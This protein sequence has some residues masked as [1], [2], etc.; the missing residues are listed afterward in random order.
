MKNLGVK[1]EALVWGGAFRVGPDHGI[2]GEEVVGGVVIVVEDVF[3]IVKVIGLVVK[4]Y[5][6]NEL[7]ME[8]RV[9]EGALN[10]QLGVYLFQLFECGA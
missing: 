10:N 7:A 9:V 4:G 2:E 1:M 5:G 6:G 3:G 8:V